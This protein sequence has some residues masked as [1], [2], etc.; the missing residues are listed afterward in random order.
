MSLEILFNLFLYMTIFN[1][2][3][4]ILVVLLRLVLHRGFVY[5]YARHLGIA[6]EMVAIVTMRWLVRYKILI[7]FLPIKIE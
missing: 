1:V 4:C 3:L 6:E 5:I 7:V 2:C